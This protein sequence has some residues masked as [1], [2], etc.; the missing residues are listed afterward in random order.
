MSGWGRSAIHRPAVARSRVCR[1]RCSAS[2]QA[3]PQASGRSRFP[4]HTGSKALA[5]GLPC[6]VPADAGRTDG[7]DCHRQRR[8]AVCSRLPHVRSGK[9]PFAARRR[10]FPIHPS[11]LQITHVTVTLDGSIVYDTV[12]LVFFE[13]GAQKL[14]GWFGGFG[15]SGTM[16]LWLCQEESPAR[17]DSERSPVAGFPDYPAPREEGS[18]VPYARCE[19]LRST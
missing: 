13:H 5:T 12:I 2:Y 3:T 14:L 19:S 17:G 9:D 4:R 1:A 11:P 16:R 10:P 8:L 15:F 18:G 7:G 6:S